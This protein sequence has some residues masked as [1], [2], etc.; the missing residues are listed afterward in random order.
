MID[1]SATCRCTSKNVHCESNPLASEPLLILAA[2]PALP[3]CSY[4]MTAAARAP[5]IQSQVHNPGCDPVAAGLPSKQ[6][7]S[8]RGTPWTEHG[9]GGS[10]RHMAEHPSAC[11]PWQWTC[12]AAAAA[13]L[14]PRRRQ[15]GP[16]GPGS[17][18]SPPAGGWLRPARAVG[19]SGLCTRRA[20]AGL[21]VWCVVRL[22]GDW[23]R[24]SSCWCAEAGRGAVMCSEAVSC[25]DDALQG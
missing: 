7:P 9:L 18:S 12:W 21:A 13:Q 16:P 25:C 3:F 22:P 19:L 15:S 23:L 14:G 20:V 2:S 4:P 6:L 24:H 1:S 8:S 11:G 17:G 10:L 5:S